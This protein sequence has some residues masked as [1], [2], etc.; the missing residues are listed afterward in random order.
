MTL[1]TPK[2]TKEE[3]AA[4]TREE[5]LRSVWLLDEVIDS[6]RWI[7]VGERLP[8]TKYSVLVT[9]WDGIVTIANWSGSKWSTCYRWDEK[10]TA[11]MPLPEPYRETN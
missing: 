2:P 3:R 5:L 1:R 10:V 4:M 8:K 9:T 11:W 6:F 7:P